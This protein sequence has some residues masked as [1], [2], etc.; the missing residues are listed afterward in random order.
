MLTGCGVPGIP[1][2]PRVAAEIP[3]VSHAW[4]LAWLPR[5]WALSLALYQLSSHS[6]PENYN[7]IDLGSASDLNKFDVFVVLYAYLV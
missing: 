4:P 6:S 5:N 3:S 7:F 1:H 2:S